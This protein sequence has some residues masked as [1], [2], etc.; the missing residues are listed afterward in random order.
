M[1]WQWLVDLTQPKH[2]ETLEE[3]EEAD[4][5]MANFKV[6]IANGY[7]WTRYEERIGKWLGLALALIFCLSV[8]L[9]FIATRHKC[10]D[11]YVEVRMPD[12]YHYFK[13]G[14]ENHKN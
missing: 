13:K 8:S 5:C 14:V 1:K 3:L 7:Q 12:G 4:Q 6:A 9:V 2:K 11:G 10:P